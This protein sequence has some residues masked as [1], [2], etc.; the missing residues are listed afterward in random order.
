LP[1]PKSESEVKT[2][3]SKAVPAACGLSLC[4][5]WNSAWKSFCE[6]VTFELLQKIDVIKKKVSQE[7]HSWNIHYG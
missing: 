3:R 1:D 2:D 6:F 7:N 4:R 5:T